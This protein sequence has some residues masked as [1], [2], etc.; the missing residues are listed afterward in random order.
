MHHPNAP[1]AAIASLPPPAGF[2]SASGFVGRFLLIGIAV[3]AAFALIMT[4]PLTVT[5]PLGFVFFAYLA[6]TLVL[7]ASER[8]RQRRRA[9]RGRGPRGTSRLRDAPTHAQEPDA[10]DRMP[11]AAGALAAASIG[12]VTC[13][14]KRID[15]MERRASSTG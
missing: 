12:P 14:H 7:S 9:S 11:S 13:F 4:A 3:V 2:P 1:I 6:G 15:E 5:V 10:T 8:L